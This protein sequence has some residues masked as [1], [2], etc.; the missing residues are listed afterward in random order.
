MNDQEINEAVARKL[1]WK[2]DGGIGWIQ[3]E[4]HPDGFLI[5]HAVLPDYCHSIA[6]AWEV[7]EKTRMTIEPS[8]AGWW[9][10]FPHA[11]NKIWEHDEI[12][13]RASSLAFLKRP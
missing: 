7:V 13:P 2:Q 8:E 1:G 6:A 12:A 10:G 3:P 9:A 11:V 4:P 5:G